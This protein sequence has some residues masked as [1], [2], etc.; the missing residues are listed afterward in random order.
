MASLISPMARSLEI[1]PF[2]VHACPRSLHVHAHTEMC[3]S[4][5]TIPSEQHYSSNAALVSVLLLL[6][7]WLGTMQIWVEFFKKVRPVSRGCAPCA[8]FN[9][10]HVRDMNKL[11]SD[12]NFCCNVSEMSRCSMKKI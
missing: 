12:L 1:F 4:M 3:I 9:E 8:L 2:F 11:D 10:N 6:Y 5:Q 7:A